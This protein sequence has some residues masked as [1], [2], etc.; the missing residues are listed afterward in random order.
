MPWGKVDD[1]HYD[2]RKVD[3]L[4]ELEGSPPTTWKVVGD[5]VFWLVKLLFAAVSDD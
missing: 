5:G 1:S 2:H 4:V 3:A